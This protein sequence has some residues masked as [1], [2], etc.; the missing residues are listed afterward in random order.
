MWSHESAFPLHLLAPIQK[1]VGHRSNPVKILLGVQEGI[2]SM[3]LADHF[4]DL[5]YCVAKRPIASRKEGRDNKIKSP[6]HQPIFLQQGIPFTV[7]DQVVV[8]GSKYT[9]KI[10]KKR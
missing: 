6:K 2:E 9:R 3:S 5:A 4:L 10:K 1:K 7:K 8:R